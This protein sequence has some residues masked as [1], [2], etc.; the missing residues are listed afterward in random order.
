MKKVKDLTTVLQVL[1]GD[2]TGTASLGRRIPENGMVLGGTYSSSAL[3]QTRRRRE[4][5]KARRGL[6]YADDGEPARMAFLLFAGATE[7]E[8]TIA[9]V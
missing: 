3:A 5:T 8:K 7:K 1:T 4:P 6:L 2:A 9:G